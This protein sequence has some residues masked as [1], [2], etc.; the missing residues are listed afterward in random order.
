MTQRFAGPIGAL[1]LALFTAAC[2]AP[3]ADTPPAPTSLDDVARASLA[4]IDGQL[5]VAGLKQPVTIVRDQQG[6]PHI[7]AQS[8]D[9][10]FFAQGYVMAQDRLW[11]LE[12]WRRWHEGRLAEV[13]GPK[14]YD[15]D[16]RTRLMMFRGP[17]DEAEWKSYHPDAE[18]LFTAWANGLN[19]W[20]AQN[21]GNL[22]VEFKLTGITPEPW[23]AKTLTLRW[24]QLGLNSTSGHPIN[25]IQLAQSVAKLGAAEANRRAAP[26]PWEDLTVPE[27]LDLRTLPADLLEV[28]RRGDGDPFESRSLPPLDIV[29]PYRS[30]VPPLKVARVRPELQDM[31]GSNNWVVSGQHT[32]TGVPIVSNDPH[33]TIEMPSL[34]YFVHLNAPGW[35]VL[36]GGEPPFVGVDAGH[37]DHMAWGFTFA[38]VDMADVFVED[39]NPADQNQARYKDAWEP[40]TLIREEIRVKGEE[41]PRAIEL[42]FTRHGPVFYEDTTHHRAYVAKSVNQERGTAPF[43]GSLKLAQAA[44]CEDF[45]DR[46]M[47]WKTPTHNLIC[48]DD[49]GN[50][51]LQVSGLTPDRTG[52]SGRLPVPGASGKYEWQGFRSDLPR[53]YNPERGYI[54][55]ANDNSHPP[56]YKGRPVLFRTTREVEVSRIARIRQMLDRAIASGKK[57]TVQDLA[58]MQ[59]D[60]YSLRAE[61]DMPL[62]KGWTAKDADVEKA[63]AMVETWDRVLTK[64]T[65]AGAIYVRWAT[66]PSG[67]QAIDA[68]PGAERQ[69]LVEEGLAQALQRLSK[70]WGS[71]WSQW[72]YGRIN[73]S[74]LPHMFVDAFNLP[75]IERP[76]GFNTVNATGANF[77]RV[78]DLSNLDNSVATNAPGQSAQPGSPYYGNLREHL[79]DGV[80]FPLPFTRGAVDKAAAH[81]LTLKP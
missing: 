53:E 11:Q 20:V 45:F 18:R 73:E 55:T 71:D 5:T 27:G 3:S 67:E 64:D 65:T 9:D 12:M 61:R 60:A 59:Q 62:F 28:A 15:Y 49:K 46:A 23:T 50:I 14:A 74:K 43:K 66:S 44:S 4:T 78:M 40:M 81:T 38:G 70:D 52:W 10:L 1:L 2:S 69:K 19:A 32:S 79:A 77:R 8:D 54:A 26:D 80:Y 24:A 31:E 51:A 33:R 42:K 25:E 75:S 21:A 76:G 6:I 29:E 22:P 48:G 30:L 7:Y 16:A 56:G 13:F 57:L 72:R 58:G 41:K 17:W 63:R 68:K 37:N 47:S 39:T 34:R 35:N 36:G